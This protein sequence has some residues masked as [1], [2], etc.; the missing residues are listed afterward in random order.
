MSSILKKKHWRQIF[1]LFLS[2][3][4]EAISLRSSSNKYAPS[5]TYASNEQEHI[6]LWGC[7]KIWR[8]LGLQCGCNLPPTK[9][10]RLWSEDV[11][12]VSPR[13]CTVQSVLIAQQ[14]RNSILRT[15]PPYLESL[16]TSLQHLRSI[17]KGCWL[18]TQIHFPEA[19]FGT[20]H[21]SVLMYG[22]LYQMQ[23]DTCIS[24][25]FFV[26]V[27]STPMRTSYDW[28]EKKEE[29]QFRLKLVASQA[30]DA[31]SDIRNCMTSH[32]T[33][34]QGSN[35]GWTPWESWKVT[36]FGF[37]SHQWEFISW[38]VMKEHLKKKKA[39]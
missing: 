37:C 18:W 29:T 20:F 36:V 35:R 34:A 4:L 33:L 25:I 23:T 22:R 30:R 8:I 5:T 14:S 27:G 21:S 28:G 10:L 38:E 39:I 26:Q 3:L 7:V 13:H 16:R 24:S 31:R 2:L 32:Q 12:Y 15:G 6:N 1:K 11:F 9:L 19:Y 17:R